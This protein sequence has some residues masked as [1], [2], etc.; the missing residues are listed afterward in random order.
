[1][2]R[3]VGEHSVEAVVCNK[4]GLHARAAA[5]VATLAETLGAEVFLTFEGQTVSTL[6]IMGMMMLGAAKGAV[7][8]V[9]S[10]GGDAVR[11]AE[12]V[13]ALVNA[14]FNESD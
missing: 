5:R 12:Q 4:R 11:A 2:S 10:S 3:E 9:S 8:V 14:G 7:L 13:A 1:M 6:S